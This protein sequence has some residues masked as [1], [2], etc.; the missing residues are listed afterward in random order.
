MTA[1]LKYMTY[2]LCILVA[3]AIANIKMAIGFSPPMISSLSLRKTPAT[4]RAEKGATY[5]AKWLLQ[6]KYAPPSRSQ[7]TLVP[8][9][10]EDDC[11]ILRMAYRVGNQEVIVSQV[12]FMMLCQVNS[13]QSS[14]NDLIPVASLKLVVPQIFQ[15][16]NLDDWFLEPDLVTGNKKP[17]TNP[18][19]AFR[20]WWQEPGRLGFYQ[21]KEDGSLR[22]A[23]P[24]SMFGPNARWFTNQ[25]NIGVDQNIKFEPSIVFQQL[26]AQQDTPRLT[27][28][29]QQ[30]LEWV[31]NRMTPEYQ[32]PTGLLFVALPKERNG[33]L[34]AAQVRYEV[35]QQIL[36]VTYTPTEIIV[37][38]EQPGFDPLPLLS[39]DDTQALARRIF[40]GAQDLK[41]ISTNATATTATGV[42]KVGKDSQASYLNGMTWQQDSGR[43]IF[44]LKKPAP[45]KP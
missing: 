20:G 11:D 1:S 6:P 44:T 26:I 22:S 17:V 9:V 12:L 38:V 13:T 31:H 27:L 33:G 18:K 30:A 24:T 45:V 21:V 39:D 41:I 19:G 10:K 2:I 37:Q 5:Y 16:N 43:V 15:H 32:L 7:F 42:G 36:T 35:D 34:E 14:P 23:V 28:L 40:K 3:F 4:S 29:R 25:A 8:R